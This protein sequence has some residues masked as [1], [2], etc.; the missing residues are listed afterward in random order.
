MALIRLAR[1][2]QLLATLVPHL[3]EVSIVISA[4]TVN[5]RAVQI[6]NLTLV[7][8]VVTIS[9]KERTSR[10][11]VKLV[12]DELQALKIQKCVIPRVIQA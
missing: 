4:G 3:E 11:N 9:Q 5:A 6:M 12:L 2:I 10:V 1:L 7:Q 8:L